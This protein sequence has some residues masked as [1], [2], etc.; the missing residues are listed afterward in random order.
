MA[1]EFTFMTDVESAAFCRQIVQHMI[2]LFHISEEEALGRVNRHFKGQ[3][4]VGSDRMI[5]HQDEEYWAKAVYYTN[6]AM[7]W[8]EH[9]LA[10]HELKPKPYP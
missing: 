7:W 1:N 3:S 9:W 2:R 10:E 4:I 6:D 5:Y 8:S